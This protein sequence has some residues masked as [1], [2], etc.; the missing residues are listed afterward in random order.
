M[1]LSL[2][3]FSSAR[4]SYGV[5]HSTHAL[6][7]NPVVILYVY[8]NN[9]RKIER[10]RFFSSDHNRTPKYETV[11]TLLQ[12]SKLYQ[13]THGFN[14]I[15]AEK[16]LNTFYLEI[17]ETATFHEKQKCVWLKTNCFAHL[18]PRRPHPRQQCRCV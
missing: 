1:L 15:E 14:T 16:K 11:A 12:A 5:Y 18:R 2:L 10:P 4:P 3:L 6:P 9:N 7:K 13:N 8:N 17:L